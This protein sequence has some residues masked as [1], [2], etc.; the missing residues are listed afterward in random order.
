MAFH[1]VRFPVDISSGARGGPERRTEIVQIAS[2][3]EERNQR[4]AN[5]RR[6]YD[7]AYGVQTVNDVFAVVE[8][9]E[10]RRARLHGFRWKDYGDYK[11]CDPSSTVSSVDQDI[12]IG[13]GVTAAFQIIKTYGSVY[14]PWERDIKKP[15]SG[16]VLVSVDTVDQVLNTDFV[17]DTTTGIITF[18]AGSIPAYGASI[19]AG[20][21]F[22][23]PVRFDADQLLVTH[24]AGDLSVIDSVPIVEIRI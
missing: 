17:L 12:A 1:E 3:Y 18:L 8:F 10:E 6:R 21:E 22:D 23:V 5:S 16:T 11:S 20:Y 15:V 4:W 24:E 7:A 2:G 13:D 9:F 14:A 19:A